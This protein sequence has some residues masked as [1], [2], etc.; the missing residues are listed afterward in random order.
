MALGRPEVVRP[1][2]NYVPGPIGGHCVVSNA[3]LFKGVGVES[4]EPFRSLIIDAGKN[5]L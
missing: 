3:M 1:V 5:E 2:L 4:L